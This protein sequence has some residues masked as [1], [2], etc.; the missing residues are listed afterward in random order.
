MSDGAAAA[1][2]CSQEG[3]KRICGD[4]SRA[5]RISASVM[6][7]FSKRT[8]AEPEKSVA[9]LT[10]PQAYEIAGIGPEDIHVAEVHDA[11]PM[12]EVPQAENL[13]LTPRG[14]GGVCAER[15]DFTIGGRVPIN[16]SGGLESKGHP[17]G[18]TGIGQLFELM[19]QQHA[20]V[21]RPSW[22]LARRYFQRCP[23]RAELCFRQVVRM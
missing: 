14:L 2:L 20:P 6:R 17:L 23:V 22:G 11:S 5:I 9:A 7:S 8:M 19:T 15:T 12:G 4:K 10:A 1:I 3:L 13:G 16:P 21:R 18:A